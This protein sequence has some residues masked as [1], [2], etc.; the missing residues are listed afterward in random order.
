VF[1]L[2]YFAKLRLYAAPDDHRRV[3]AVLKFL[4]A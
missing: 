2:R 3:L 4:E 1:A